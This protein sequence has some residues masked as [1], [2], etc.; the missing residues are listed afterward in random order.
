MIADE[1]TSALDQDRQAAFLSLLFGE[2]ERI[3]A[4]LIMVSHDPR[5]GEHFD[6]IVRLDTI[7]TVSDGAGE[8]S[9]RP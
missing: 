5:L 3:G 1:P 9:S 4:T 8:R 2:L 6:E 7:A